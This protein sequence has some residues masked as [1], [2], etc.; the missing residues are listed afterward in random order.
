MHVCM[1]MCFVR[2]SCGFSGDDPVGG[3]CVHF[4]T[5][6]QKYHNANNIYIDISRGSLIGG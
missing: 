3:L 4:L 2:R 5:F 1:C 6:A